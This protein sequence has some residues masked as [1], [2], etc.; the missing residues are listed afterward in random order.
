MR[1][2]ARLHAPMVR[3][4]RSPRILALVAPDRLDRYRAKRDFGATPEP[5]GAEAQ[6][7]AGG[8]RFVVHEHQA[9]NL[10]WDLRLERDGVLV[11]FALPRGLP[12]EPSRNRL[13]VH[14]EDHPLEYV[15]FSGEIPAGQYGAGTMTIFDHGSYAAEKFRDDEIILTLHGERVEGRFALFRTEGRNWMIHRMDGPQDPGREPFPRGLEPML[16]KPSSLPR[17]DDA[18]AYE[19]KWDGVRALAYV[20]GGH[21]DLC[22]RKGLDMTATY[23]ELHELG[24]ALGMTEAVLDGEIVAFDGSGRPSFERLQRRINVGSDAAVRRLVR[25]VPVSYA[26]FDLLW[27][28]GHSTRALPYRERRRLLEGL[29]LETAH[30]R[31][32]AAHVGGGAALLAATEAQGLEGVVAKRLDSTYEP[33]RR[34][35]AW[36]KVR[37]PQTVVCTIG[38]FTRGEG[39]RAKSIGAL[40]LGREQEGVGLVYVGRVGSGI[41]GATLDRLEA[42]LAPLVADASPFA[43][44]A[45]PRGTIF[46][47][48][49]LACTVSY[50][51]WTASGTLRHPVFKGLARPT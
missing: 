51:E 45:V 49:R 29:E 22:S 14:T 47:E 19:I 38:G 23:P 28:D 4:R 48:P 3:G 2:E 17:D 20:S 33:G 43:R 35:G 42:A 6:G 34:S 36:I 7:A 41:A 25:D 26:L 44:G 11:S 50:T 24:R 16:A 12:F 10:H 5:G 46:V 13:A 9:R 40:A 37:N 39:G 8:A 15:D 1:F 18:Y 27:L 30:V 32:P 21:V 31:V